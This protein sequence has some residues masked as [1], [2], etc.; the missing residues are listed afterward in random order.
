MRIFS[1][2]QAT[3]N[4]A[5]PE[6]PPLRPLAHQLGALERQ[7]EALLYRVQQLERR[8]KSHRNIE[9]SL[10]REIRALKAEISGEPPKRPKRKRTAAATAPPPEA[11]DDGFPDFGAVASELNG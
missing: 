3:P 11:I 1:N 9:D 5:A 2:T 10:R 6:P 8:E 7:C 4:R